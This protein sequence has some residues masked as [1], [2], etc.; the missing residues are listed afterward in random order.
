MVLGRSPDL[1]LQVTAA[2][3]E[4]TGSLH[5]VRVRRLTIPRLPSPLELKFVL[6]YLRGDIGVRSHTHL[7]GS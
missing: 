3:A 1:R 4:K 6:D 2:S 7:V 5:P